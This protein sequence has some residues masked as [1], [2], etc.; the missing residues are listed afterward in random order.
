[1]HLFAHVIVE[2]YGAAYAVANFQTAA[3]FK[4]EVTSSL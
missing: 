2:I 3:D 1:M 4:T